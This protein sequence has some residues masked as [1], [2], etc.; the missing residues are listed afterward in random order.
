MFEEENKLTA[1]KRKERAQGIMEF[2]LAFPILL[3]IFVALFE[4]GRVIFVL[5][6]VYTASREAVRY[7]ITF[8]KTADYTPH[9]LD[10][11][12]IKDKA[13]S[14]GGPGDVDAADVTITYDGGPGTPSIGT[15]PVNAD[16]LD[17]GDRIIVQVVGHY[18]PAAFVPLIDLPTF[19]ITAVTRRTL[20]QEV[21]IE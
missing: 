18:T 15:C 12:G 10:C 7:G 19:D 16:D 11:A 8:G 14:F 17:S 5:N 9:Y 20:I 21:N 3:A 13:T 4:F 6:S 1:M 2:A